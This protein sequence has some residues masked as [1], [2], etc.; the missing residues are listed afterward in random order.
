VTAGASR[1]KGAIR[2]PSFAPVVVEVSRAAS[3]PVRATP[4]A[5]RRMRVPLVIKLGIVG[6]SARLWPG[7]ASAP[8]GAARDVAVRDQGRHANCWQIV[9][10]AL[11]KPRITG[12]G[13]RC[14]F[15]CASRLRTALGTPPST[16]D[17][18]R[19]C[20]S[21]G[22]QRLFGGRRPRPVAPPIAQVLAVLAVGRGRAF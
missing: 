2:D 4:R 8:E 7:R 17:P 13:H 11:H 22:V 18:T 10:C 9:D 15:C 6:S 20:L 21:H 16:R 12:S 14:L 3:P 19:S 1:P 5:N